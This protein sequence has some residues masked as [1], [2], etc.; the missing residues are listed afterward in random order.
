M[1]RLLASFDSIACVGEVVASKFRD[2]G[3]PVVTLQPGVDVETLRLIAGR[4]KPSPS[5]EKLKVGFVNHFTHV[6][7][8]D[9]ASHLFAELAVRRPEVDFVLAGMG[10]L[11]QQVRG[12]VS[13]IPNVEVMGY[14]EMTERMQL[15]ASLDVLVLPFR[16]EVSVLGV[17][18]TVLEAMALDT[19]VVGA[20]IPAISSAVADG[21]EGLIVG[22]V[23]G[24]MAA[25]E[26]LLDDA[27]QRARLS[28]DARKRVTR[29]YNMDDRVEELIALMDISV[30]GLDAERVGIERCGE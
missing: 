17:A 23:D 11:E 16:T 29:Q 19:V 30:D 5:D 24:Y 9:I 21:V 7:G 4:P 18:Q 28:E 26:A 10:S 6:K 15:L 13:G 8:A 25:V 20:D 12:E 27:P 1:R 3:V 22:D 2:A 14:V